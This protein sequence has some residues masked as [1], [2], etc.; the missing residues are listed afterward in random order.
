MLYFYRRVAVFLGLLH[1]HVTK[2]LG[3]LKAGTVLLRFP[4]VTVKKSKTSTHVDGDFVL[5][6]NRY[7]TLQMPTT[8]LIF[9]V[10]P[11]I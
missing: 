3:C 9:N 10:S 7:I 11:V 4:F 2:K 6:R 5:S 8:F 1:S